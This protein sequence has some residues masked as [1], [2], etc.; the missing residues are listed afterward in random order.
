VLLAQAM[1]VLAGQAQVVLAAGQAQL[2]PG[3][4]LAGRVVG[5]RPVAVPGAAAVQV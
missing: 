3:H 2:V 5:P 4:S 1:R